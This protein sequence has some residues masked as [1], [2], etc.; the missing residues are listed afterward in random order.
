[1]I[2]LHFSFFPSTMHSR[3]HRKWSGIQSWKLKRI[4]PYVSQIVKWFKESCALTM[5]KRAL[6]FFARQLLKPSKM[7]THAMCFN[8]LFYL[9]DINLSNIIKIFVK[10]I[11]NIYQSASQMF[12]KHAKRCWMHGLLKFFVL[13][14]FRKK[15]VERGKF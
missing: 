3:V 10:F 1:M 14:F 9:N 12:K 11:Q 7:S 6:N 13:N 2:D 8:C 15:S 5:H 4:F